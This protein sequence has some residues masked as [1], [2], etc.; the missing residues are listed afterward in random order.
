L[1]GQVARSSA[2]ERTVNNHSKLERDSLRRS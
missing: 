1:F 2:M